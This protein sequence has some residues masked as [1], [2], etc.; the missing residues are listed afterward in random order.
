M[1]AIF[2][3]GRSTVVQL[4]RRQFL[5]L[6]GAAGATLGLA[7][8]GGAPPPNPGGAGGG[9]GEVVF[10]TWGGDYQRFGQD[11]VEPVL[12][13]AD[14]APTVVYDV[15]DHTSRLTKMRTQAGGPGTIDVAAFAD[16]QAQEATDAGLL[17]R[18]D[19]A[20]LP[21]AA[22]IR[23]DFRS[24]LWVPHIYS[25]GVIIYNTE[26]VTTPPD[27]FEVFWDPAYT[28]RIGIQSIQWAP[29]YF[30]AAALEAGGDPGNNWDAGWQRMLARKGTV[31]V[32]ESQEQLGQAMMSGEVW[33][34]YNWKARAYLWNKAGQAPLAAA[35]PREG[36]MPVV[37]TVSIPANAPNPDGAYAH[38]NAM[39]DP[40]AQLQFA[41]N[42][43]YWPTVTNVDPPPELTSQI[44]F[45]PEEEQKIYPVD[46]S[47]LAQNNERWRQQYVEQLINN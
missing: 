8:C 35:I 22:N 7:A 46:L 41:Q 3:E 16:S 15:G 26:H 30:M 11:F 29:E 47:Y 1:I 40:E 2:G 5:S 44:G 25:A 10:G 45:T 28:G 9:A 23:E 32:Y 38:I 36:T 21:N 24:D 33:L 19:P 31:R 12:A 34:A 14:G 27:S 20:Q 42:M 39:L 18:I 37:F 6:A 13:R 17:A 43:G 4:P